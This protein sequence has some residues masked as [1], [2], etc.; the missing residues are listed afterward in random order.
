MTERQ[1]AS[2][3][4]PAILRPALVASFASSTRASSSATR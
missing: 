3:F 2:L 4:D 1:S